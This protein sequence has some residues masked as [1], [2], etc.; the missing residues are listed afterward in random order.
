VTG[1]K[2][3]G[4]A[5]S[6]VADAWGRVRGVI[7]RMKGRGNH[8]DVARGR[9]S[10]DLMHVGDRVVHQSGASGRVREPTGRV[11]VAVV[12]VGG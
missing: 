3:V 8:V 9:M 11:V 1:R 5:S 6:K 2:P 7:A 10:E 12:P 4:G